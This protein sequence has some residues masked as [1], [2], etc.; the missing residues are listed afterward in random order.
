MVGFE[1]GPFR[2]LDTKA[3]QYYYYVF[4]KL[5][6]YIAYEVLT[7][8]IL[9]LAYPRK[10]LLHMIGLISLFRLV[11]LIPLYAVFR[12]TLGVEWQLLKAFI[13]N[14]AM[15]PILPALLL[16]AYWL[17]ENLPSFQTKQ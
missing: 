11:L 17:Q 14:L 13:H 16:P 8:A 5:S 12:N 15:N 3:S 4:V 6:K 7:W 1:L 10:D 9:L 2:D